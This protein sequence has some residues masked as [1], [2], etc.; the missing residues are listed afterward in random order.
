MII[1]FILL[2]LWCLLAN[3]FS[4]KTGVLDDNPK[5]KWKFCLYSALLMSLVMGL[6]AVTVGSDTP[7]YLDRYESALGLL[8]SEY[9]ATEPGYNILNFISHDFLG[10][11]YTTFLLLTSLFFCLV[12]ARFIYHFSTDSLFSFFIHLT[13]GSFAMSMSGIR[14]CLAISFCYMALIFLYRSNYKLKRLLA[15]AL[16]LLAYTFHNS[17]FFF[18][19]FVLIPKIRL[20]KTVLLGIGLLSLLVFVFNDA[21]GSFILNYVP[22]RYSEF[23]LNTKYHA[24]IWVYPVPASILLFSFF[25]ISHSRHQLLLS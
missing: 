25:C 16:V 17:A 12:L 2:L 1:Y 15:I 20:S 4:P 23:S 9:V 10:L 19:P 5:N 14:Q 18:L 8:T 24:N 13:I 22:T 7:E 11:S 3:Y 6:R 21:I